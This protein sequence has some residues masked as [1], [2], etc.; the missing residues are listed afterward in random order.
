MSLESGGSGG[1]VWRIR[2]SP[3]RLVGSLYIYLIVVSIYLSISLEARGVEA[4]N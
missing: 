2:S 3:T 4:E 1:V